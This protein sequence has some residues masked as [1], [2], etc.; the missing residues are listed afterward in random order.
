MTISYS[1]EVFTSTGTGIFLRL[2]ARWKGSI[3]KL[4]WRDLLVYVF[5]YSALSIIYRFFLVEEGK[6]PESIK[7]LFFTTINIEMI[8]NIDN[9]IMISTFS[10]REQFEKISLHC[11]HFADLI[12]VTFVLGFYVNVVIT[13]WWQ[14]FESI[15]WPG[16]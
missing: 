13:R 14:Q 5:V 12:P 3:Y 9:I 11:G 6:C 7:I 4:V 2:L 8:W 10:A 15:P 16:K 1:R